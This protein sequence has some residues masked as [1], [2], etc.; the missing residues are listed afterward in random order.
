MEQKKGFDF[1]RMMTL[2]ID[3]WLLQKTPFAKFSSPKFRQCNANSTVYYL[4]H[5]TYIFTVSYQPYGEFF[6]NK[7]NWISGQVTFSMQ[8]V[9]YF[10]G[11]ELLS[12]I[13]GNC[14]WNYILW[15]GTYCYHNFSVVFW[16]W[17]HSISHRWQLTFRSVWS[18]FF[19]IE[20]PPQSNKLWFAP[21]QFST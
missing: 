17:R 8:T 18:D 10:L 7:R 2:D 20:I 9:I 13:G 11:G 5:K 4:G 12:K 19:F 14:S 3:I 21:I 1:W 6:L 16:P 15:T